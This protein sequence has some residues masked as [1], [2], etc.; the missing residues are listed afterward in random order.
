MADITKRAATGTLFSVRNLTD[1]TRNNSPANR[2]RSAWNTNFEAEFRQPLLQGAGIDFNRIAGPRAVPGVYNGVL[3]AH[4]R[5]DISLAE[6]E[7][8]VQDLLRDVELTYWRLHFAYR[9]LDAIV[10]GR[11][12]A[13]DTWQLVQRQLQARIADREQESLARELYFAAEAAVQNA[14]SGGADATAGGVLAV[15]RQLRLLMGLPT[16]TAP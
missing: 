11:D 5:T 3:I 2:F 15:E 10:A 16:N 12:A 9:E 4:I 6:F 14:M 7:Q 8:A 13:L 1:Y